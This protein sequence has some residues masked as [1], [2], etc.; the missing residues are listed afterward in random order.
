MPQPVIV[1][2]IRTPFGR[3]AGYYRETRPDN[4]LAHALSGLVERSGID[5]AQLD[6]VITGCVF[7]AQEQ[8]ANVSRLGSLL[9]GIPASVPAVSVNR[10]CG[11]SQQALI[12]AAQ[13]VAAGDARYVAAAG[14]ESLTRVPMYTDIGGLDKL[15][16]QLAEHYELVH[17]GESG[18]RIAEQWGISRA[19]ADAFGTES[20]RR[21]ATAARASL[22]REILP[23]PAL[24]RDGNSILAV[25]DE[26]IR[27]NPDPAKAATLPTV[28]R[29]AGNGIVTAANSSQIADGASALLMADAEAALADGLRPRARVL[30][31]AFVGSDP[32]LSLTGVI[33]ATRKALARA[34]MTIDDLD[35]I[36]IN[37]AFATVVLAWAHDLKADLAKVN[38]WGGAIAHGHP[39]GATG[40]GLMAKLLAGLEQSG[41]TLGLLTICIGHGQATA[42]IIERM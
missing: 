41:G 42:T 9:A 15:N 25:R 33:P 11:S 18:E 24:D 26:G 14:V 5:A 23:T 3:Q 40:V 37:E 21:A 7:Q 1:E 22:H 19:A 2:A 17:Q 12:F 36:E 38:P 16:P 29:P 31:R 4:L 10:W 32:T 13:A 28:F 39:L 35:W 8:G 20:H 30:A 27:E 34:G 6:D